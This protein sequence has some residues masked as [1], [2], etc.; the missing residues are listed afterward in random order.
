MK[1]LYLYPDLCTGCN[2]CAMACSLNKFGECNPKRAAII[3]V[4]DEFERYESPVLCMQCETPVCIDTCPEKAY[5]KED[6]IIKKDNDKCIGCK[7]C[8]MK[9]PNYAINIFDRETIKCDLC[10]GDPV[11]VKYCSTGAIK[12]EGENDFLMA[13]RRKIL[14]RLIFL[15][16][17]EMW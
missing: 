17:G 3:I 6:G 14:K 5:F 12:Y 4:R 9:C 1:Y 11:C 2:Q 8:S 10:S 16:K 13:S 15:N 7:T